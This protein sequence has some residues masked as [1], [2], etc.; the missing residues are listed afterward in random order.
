MDYE[1]CTQ[2][3]DRVGFDQRHLIKQQRP[4]DF[5]PEL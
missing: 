4:G 3:V 2:R 1:A 5:F